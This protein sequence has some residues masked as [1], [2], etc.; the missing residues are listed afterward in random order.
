MMKD[1]SK[2]SCIKRVIFYTPEETRYDTRLSEINI[3]GSAS[4]KS[5]PIFNVS[6]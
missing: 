6:A 3:S 1:E 5:E 4:S 2:V